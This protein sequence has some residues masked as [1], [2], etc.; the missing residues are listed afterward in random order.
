MAD[1]G[2]TADRCF[3]KSAECQGINVRESIIAVDE[4]RATLIN[5]NRPAASLFDQLL[6]LKVERL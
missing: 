4:F 5:L 6:Y 3:L 1:Y 2:V